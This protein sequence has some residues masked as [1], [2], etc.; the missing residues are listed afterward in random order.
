MNKR[1]HI[2]PKDNKKRKYILV[3][4]ITYDGDTGFMVIVPEDEIDPEDE[5][6]INRAVHGDWMA[7]EAAHLLSKDKD[8]FV[9]QRM[10]GTLEL[11]LAKEKK[12]D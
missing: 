7:V 6:M 3:T 11:F 2:K 1:A 5:A 9:N 4:L 12:T 8:T 10:E